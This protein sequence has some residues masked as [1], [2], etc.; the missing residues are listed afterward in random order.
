MSF[1]AAAAS[2]PIDT[3]LTFEALEAKWQS[4]VESAVEAGAELLCFPEYGAI[5]AALAHLTQ[6]EMFQTDITQTDQLSRASDPMGQIEIMAVCEARLLSFW[7]G[8]AVRYGVHIL[9]PGL[10]LMQEAGAPVNRAHFITAEGATDYQDKMMPTPFER[11]MWGM[12]AGAPLKVFDTQLGKIAVLICYDCEFPLL[13][14]AAMEAGAKILLVPSCTDNAQGYWR[15]RIGAMARALEGQ[16]V[17]IQSALIGHCEW[18]PSTDVNY[19]AAGIYGPPDLGFPETGVIAG[20]ALN[21]PN[22]VMAEIDL[23]KIDQLRREGA[24]RPFDHWP[25]QVA[26]LGEQAA[27][28]GKAATVIRLKR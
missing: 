16:C 28:L 15:V 3:L 13:A 4:W 17:V 8:M 23:D 26:S 20:G 25:E 2:Y 11:E 27:A 12:E 10:P 7:Q 1:I 18:S 5:E 19:G 9:S 24:V 22:W 6:G 14:R 21:E